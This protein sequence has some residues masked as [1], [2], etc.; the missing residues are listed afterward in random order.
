MRH[1]ERQ[2]S[3]GYGIYAKTEWFI[4]GWNSAPD[5]EEQRVQIWGFIPL[6]PGLAN[7]ISANEGVGFNEASEI[8]FENINTYD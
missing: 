7:L 2:R 6:N 1:C 3:P 5:S 4:L 8:A